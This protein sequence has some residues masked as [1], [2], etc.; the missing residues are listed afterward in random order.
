MGAV[1]D[2][3]FGTYIIHELKTHNVN[4]DSLIK[5]NGTENNISISLNT[6]D[7]RSMIAFAGIDDYSELGSGKK[8]MILTSNHL[9]VKGLNME[10]ASLLKFAKEKNLST[11]LDKF[12]DLMDLN[13]ANPVQRHGTNHARIL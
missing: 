12:H 6:F 7:D 8:N 11:S 5:V 9:H 13:P 10:R 1:V 4:I 3:L 2:N